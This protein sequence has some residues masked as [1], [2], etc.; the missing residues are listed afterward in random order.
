MQSAWREYHSPI[1][2]IGKKKVVDPLF[3]QT[4]YVINDDQIV[5][6]AAIECGLGHYHI[7]AFSEKTQQRSSK[8][9]RK[10]YWSSI[11]PKKG[12]VL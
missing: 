11:D 12:G 4:F 1:I 9:I 10:K 7:F 2:V 6:F 8:R 5:F 3:G